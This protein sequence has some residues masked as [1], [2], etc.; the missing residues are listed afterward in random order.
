MTPPRKNATCVLV[1]TRG[2]PRHSSDFR[3]CAV[4]CSAWARESPGNLTESA[5]LRG[6]VP[7]IMSSFFSSG[8]REQSHLSRKAADE[9]DRAGHP[10]ACAGCVG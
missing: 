10:K 9:I 8:R 6:S 7:W 2:G 5:V 3:V 1:A 4:P